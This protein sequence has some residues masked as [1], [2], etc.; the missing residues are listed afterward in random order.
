[1]K[2]LLVTA[3]VAVVMALAASSCSGGKGQGT[4]TPRSVPTT[5]AASTTTSTTALTGAAAAAALEQLLIV[6]VPAGFTRQADDVGDTGPS[7]LAKAVRDDGDPGAQQALTAAGF[8]AG[9]Q[10]LWLNAAQDQLIVFLYQ[11]RDATGAS[12]YNQ[13]SVAGVSSGATNFT[14]SGVPG[15]QGYQHVASVGA[16]STV[17]FTKGS[18]GVQVV[19]N[20]KTTKG[21][22]EAIGPLAQ[23][24]F[25]RLPGIVA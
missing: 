8:V 24:Q 20:A 5:A 6:D 13:R 15:A 23:A 10:R 21:Q 14:V 7:D 2:R 3:V 22:V 18:Y 4:V 12:S 17:F 25:E 1:V 9:Y 11:F 16:A 19:M